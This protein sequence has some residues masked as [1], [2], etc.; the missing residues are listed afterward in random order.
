MWNQKHNIDTIA[1]VV[2]C[3]ERFHKN[4]A[5]QRNEENLSRRRFYQNE[6]EVF[7]EILFCLYARTSCVEQ[8]SND[9]KTEAEAAIQMARIT[10]SSL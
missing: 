5:A 9:F 10:R 6:L 2:W 4:K 8:R 3:Q 1:D 7:S